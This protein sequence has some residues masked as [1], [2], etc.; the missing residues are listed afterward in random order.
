MLDYSIIT[1][2][3]ILVRGGVYDYTRKKGKTG[4]IIKKY[5]ENRRS[6]KDIK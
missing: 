5:H 1:K 2:Q 3:W 6:S 4:K